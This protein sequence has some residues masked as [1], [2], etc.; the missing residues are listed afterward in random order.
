MNKSAEEENL[1]HLPDTI[2]NFFF[3]TDQVTYSLGCLYIQCF[4][5]TVFTFF[6]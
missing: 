3:V 1:P 5:I 4:A 2:G 6:L